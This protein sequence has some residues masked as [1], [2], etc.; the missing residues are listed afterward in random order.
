MA[1]KHTPMMGKLTPPTPS[2]LRILLVED[3]PTVAK[4]TTKM[5]T[6]LGHKVVTAEN[7]QIALNF[8]KE[9]P[10][11][12]DGSSKNPFDLVLMDFQMPIMD[13]MEATK[14]FR[15]HETVSRQD[16]RQLIIGLSATNDQDII[17]DGFAAGLDDYLFKPVT[18]E[19]FLLKLNKF[20][21]QLTQKLI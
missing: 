11:H 17:E 3:S 5:L 13:G 19:S 21:F 4:M 18:A 8:M 1:G 12:A 16:S 15:E 9:R 2:Q 20:S 6:K 7:G 10:S 14:R